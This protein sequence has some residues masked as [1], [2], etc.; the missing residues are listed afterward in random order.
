MLPEALLEEIS[1]TNGL[2]IKETMNHFLGVKFENS[3]PLNT[4]FK[5]FTKICQLRHCVVHRFG[6]LGSYNAI[7]LGLSEHKLFLEK[8]IQID[9]DH[10]NEIVQICENLVKVINNYLYCEILQRTFQNRTEIWHFDFRRDKKTFKKYF[11]LFKDS[12]SR[13]NDKEVYRTFISCMERI[14]GKN[15]QVNGC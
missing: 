4:V 11:D 14:Y 3:E 8:P 15:Y 9:F 5:E 10:L 12:S 7:E 6:F 13:I 2:N 1:F